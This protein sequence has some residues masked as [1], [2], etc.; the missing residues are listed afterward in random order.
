MTTTTTPVQVHGSHTEQI[1][2][3]H[4]FDRDPAGH[5]LENDGVS[6]VGNAAA[7]PYELA[8]FVCEG[9]YEAG[10]DRILDTYLSH[11]SRSTQPSAWISGFYGSGKS[12]L[13]K[14]L[15]ALWRDEP[16]DDGRRPRDIVR[17][18][19]HIERHLRELS[20]EAR[21]A[22]GVWSASGMLSESSDQSVR[23]LI[24][25]I[26]Y[27]AAGLSGDY[28]RARFRLWIRQ[29][30]WE[31]EIVRRVTAAGLDPDT[32]FNEYLVSPVIADAVHDLSGATSTDAD[33]A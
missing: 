11:L 3:R 33:S 6:K 31:D 16:F 14:V 25:G 22:G 4:V 13:V 17:L 1:L 15:E 9:E 21:R 20:T 18:P 29:R 32:E 8:T 23:M 12:H 10:L 5:S 26:V 7:L 19:Q 28:G 30:G 27:R 2:N 24:L